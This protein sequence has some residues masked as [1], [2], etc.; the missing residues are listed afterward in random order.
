MQPI[1]RDPL[2]GHL[3]QTDDKASYSGALDVYLG[4]DVRCRF[5]S[6]AFDCRPH[7][8]SH[9]SDVLV[10]DEGG[11]N[12][13]MVLGMIFDIVVVEYVRLILGLG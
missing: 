11:F 8:R 4:V 13:M 10:I 1:F 6:V 12:E 7:C 2:L 3:A 5:L 9:W